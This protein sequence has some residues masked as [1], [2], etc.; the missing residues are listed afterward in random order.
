MN[1]LPGALPDDWTTLQTPGAT[2][3]TESNFDSTW[4]PNRDLPAWYSTSNTLS[5]YEHL[6]RQGF[7]TVQQFR[8]GIL[9]GCIAHALWLAANDGSFA[10]N[11]QWDGDTYVDDNDQGE[12]WAVSFTAEGAVAAF[13]S[14][15]MEPCDQTRCFRGMPD[16]LRTA[17]DRALSWMMNPEGG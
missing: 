4:D 8:R 12:T 2:K 10:H 1:N 3:M 9:L 13:Y 5:I 7:P 17:K 11:H 15:E 16:T 6:A 14:S